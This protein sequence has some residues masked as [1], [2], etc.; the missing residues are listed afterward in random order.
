MIAQ[1][2]LVQV[3]D[4]AGV[5]F[6]GLLSQALGRKVIVSAPEVS[7]GGKS[8][9]ALAFPDPCAIACT[10]VESKRPGVVLHALTQPLDTLLP[11][12]IVN[13][14]AVAAPPVFTELHRGAFAELMGRYWMAAAQVFGSGF[15]MDFRPGAPE[16]IHL[17][18]GECLRKM[19]LF[20]G[21]ESF[22]LATHQIK[23]PDMATGKL[24]A[25]MPA[26]FMR[27]LLRMPAAKRAPAAAKKA[28]EES[29]MEHLNADVVTAPNAEKILKGH[30]AAPHDA[31]RNLQTLMDIPVN[32]V[33][34]LG[35]ADMEVDDI[36]TLAPGKVVELDQASGDPISLLVNG[37][38][39]A[40]GEVVTIG[41]NFGL[42]VTS[43][44]GPNERL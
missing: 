43:I 36:L 14:R 22:A 10:P 1:D 21:I 2:H 12:L 29:S 39:V 37:T 4:R 33:A 27:E 20:T 44:V 35:R 42:K 23:I 13:P 7:V 26:V 15:D 24:V 31:D 8:E 11:E 17:S 34:R 3:F 28:M 9:L 30:D 19:P 5:V 40:R 32:V 6:G 25:L 38:L 41:E 18:L 16:V